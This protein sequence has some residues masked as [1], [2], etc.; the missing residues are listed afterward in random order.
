MS[1]L[2]LVLARDL[3]FAGRIGATARSLGVEVAMLRNPAALNDR[4]GHTL[5][6]DLNQP[7]ALDAA[8]AWKTR[9]AGAVIGFTAHTDSDTISR[10]QALRIDNVLTR[11]TF[12]QQLNDLL[13]ARAEQSRGSSKP[14]GAADGNVS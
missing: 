14:E 6:V 8:A 7:G 4:A 10:A 2:I 3:M 9:T 11:G 13:L 12:V 1:D 5:I